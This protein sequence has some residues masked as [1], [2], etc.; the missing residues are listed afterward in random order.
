MIN[1]KYVP[2]FFFIVTCFITH[3]HPFETLT[4]LQT[5]T[6]LYEEFP[7]A[8]NENW[9]DLD[10]STFHKSIEPTFIERIGDFFGV[11]WRYRWDPFAFKQLLEEVTKTRDTKDLNKPHVTLLPCSKKIKHIAIWGDLHGAFH[12]LVRDLGWFYEQGI[13][14]Q[15]L[16]IVDPSYYFVFNGDSINRSPYNVETLHTLLLLLKQNPDHVF[17]IRGKHESRLY[18]QNFGLKRELVIRASRVDDSEIPL[19]SLVNRFFSTLPL[20]LYIRDAK[21]PSDEKKSSSVA[22]IRI[23]HIPTRYSEIDE[24][25]FGPFLSSC[26]QSVTHYPLSKKQPST[27]KIMM[28]A[29]VRGQDWIKENIVWKGLG[30][31]TQ[32]RGATAWGVFSSPIK[33]HRVHFNAMHDAFAIINL[34]DTIETSTISLYRQN[35]RVKDG[36]TRYNIYHLITGEPLSSLDKA[37]KPANY[38]TI[39]STMGL[40]GGV[41]AMAYR[42]QQGMTMRIEAENVQGGVNGTHIKTIVYNDSY[43]PYL[44]RQNVDYLLNDLNVKTLLLPVGSPTL[45]SYINYIRDNKLLVLFPVT[46]GPQFRSPDLKGI[47]NYRATYADEVHALIDYLITQYNIRKFAFFYQDDA[48]GHGALEAAHTALQG[49]YHA[50]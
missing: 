8:D 39:G 4:D 25:Q 34:H 42:V 7:Q 15:Q 9:L 49:M 26:K 5:Y 47:I 50:S 33:P 2:L 37:K 23:S 20:A 32:D 48:Y 28:E 13:I 45:E 16:R 35:S 41:P 22:V 44:A 12:S 21:S 19:E 24:R 40:F 30:L 3:I 27:K 36:F 1:K 11:K 14:D 43:I 46:G 18:W 29:L 38:F 10:Y 6:Q 17:Y 31:L